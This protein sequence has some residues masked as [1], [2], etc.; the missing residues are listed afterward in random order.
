MIKGISKYSKTFFRITYTRKVFTENQIILLPDAKQKVMQKVQTKAM[1][2]T[3]VL[4]KLV[5]GS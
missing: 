2:I 1:C 3:F 5:V 4:H